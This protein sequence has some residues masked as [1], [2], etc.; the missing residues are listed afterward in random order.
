MDELYEKNDDA[1]QMYVDLLTNSGFKAVFGDRAN[2]DV[3]MSV[4]NSFLPPHC[5]VSDIEYSTTEYQGQLLSNK[6]FRYD[7][8]C[9]DWS[10]SRISLILSGMRFSRASSE[11]AKLPCLMKVNEFNTTRICTT[12][13]DVWANL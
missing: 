4:M 5:H 2:K 10:I 7:F 8:M 11:P 13:K 1:V 3:V 6:E 12:K 9:K